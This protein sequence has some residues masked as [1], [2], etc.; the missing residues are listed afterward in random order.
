[1]SRSIENFRPAAPRC[2]ALILALALA[3]ASAS[4][5]S[6]NPVAPEA[7]LP[8]GG[9][10]PGSGTYT[11][12]LTASPTA[13]VAGSTDGTTL[14]AIATNSSSQSSPPDGTKCAFSTSLG[15]FDP[16]KAL[17]LTTISFSGG[18]AVATLYPST[19]TGTATVL[20]Q[21]DT[22]SRQLSVPIRAAD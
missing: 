5:N 17:T 9:G 20:A 2:A 1:M 16:T 3:V 6:K 14:T 19:T 11:I 18:K 12:T 10:G 4:C 15:S 21:I 22:S 13:L 8:P 7:P